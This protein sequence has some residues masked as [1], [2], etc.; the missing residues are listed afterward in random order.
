MSDLISPRDWRAMLPPIWY[1][2]ETGSFH[3]RAGD[4]HEIFTGDKLPEG[5]EGFLMLLLP[6]ITA[7]QGARQMLRMLGDASLLGDDLAEAT[8]RLSPECTKILRR[9]YRSRFHFALMVT[10]PRFDS[11]LLFFAT[12][13]DPSNYVT[14]IGSR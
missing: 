7:V 11:G 12:L 4:G 2:Q 13:K 5:A 9:T 14:L 8:I 1:K 3:L 6:S 10:S